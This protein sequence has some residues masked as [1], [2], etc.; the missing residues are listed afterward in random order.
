M[1]FD[2][3]SNPTDEIVRAFIRLSEET[4]EKQNMRV[5]VH[6]K[7]GLGRTGVLIGGKLTV[8]D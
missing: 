3:G 6:C 7:A 4:I 2:D 8:R 5:A 1:Y